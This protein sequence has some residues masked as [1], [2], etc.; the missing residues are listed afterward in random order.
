MALGKMVPPGPMFSAQRA[1]SKCGT[2]RETKNTARMP[3]A[4][5]V[6]IIVTLK[7]SSTPAKFS[8]T[9]MT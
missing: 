9:K 7:D 4:S 8:P 5:S 3:R 6:T 1:K 2:A